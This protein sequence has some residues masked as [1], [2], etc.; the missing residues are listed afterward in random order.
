MSSAEVARCSSRL[1]KWVAVVGAALVVLCWTAFPRAPVASPWRRAEASM[2]T[3][4]PTTIGPLPRAPVVAAGVDSG[5]QGGRGACLCPTQAVSLH[6][7]DT[8][9]PTLA[10]CECNPA[11]TPASTATC[12]GASRGGSRALP[13]LPDAAAMARLV[14]R[15]DT[16]SEQAWVDAAVPPALLAFVELRLTKLV[17]LVQIASF[18]DSLTAEDR[19]YL[20]RRLSI[21]YEAVVLVGGQLCGQLSQY[22]DSHERLAH[23]KGVAGWGSDDSGPPPEATPTNVREAILRDLQRRNSG[24]RAASKVCRTLHTKLH[25]YHDAVEQLLRDTP[26]PSWLDT[27]DASLS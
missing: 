5:T 4:P 11:S 24:W 8:A 1:W 26:A 20:L 15:L 12:E 16:L 25:R 27:A 9:A 23:D 21:N 17:S 18:D 10:A 19:A 13:D 3:P 7:S 22:V 6:D 2:T 14:P